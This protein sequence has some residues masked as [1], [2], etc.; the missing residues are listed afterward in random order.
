MVTREMLGEVI[1]EAESDS[2]AR[3]LWA[4]H[5]GDREKIWFHDEVTRY[6]LYSPD[7]I[8]ECLR[9]KKEKP[10]RLP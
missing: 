10:G 4:D 1:W 9:L 8:A 7:Q 3:Q 6:M 2:E 5:P